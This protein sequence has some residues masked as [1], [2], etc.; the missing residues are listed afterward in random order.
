MTKHDAFMFSAYLV[1]IALGVD[2]MR[3]DWY[4]GFAQVLLGA[5]VFGLRAHFL[6]KRWNRNR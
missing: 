4:L 3:H 6:A 2:M 5:G 1:I